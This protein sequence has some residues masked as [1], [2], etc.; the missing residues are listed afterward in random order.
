MDENYA[1]KD[2]VV[3]NQNGEAHRTI[4]PNS[5][6]DDHFFRFLE[7]VSASSRRSRTV[8]YALM[9]VMIATYGIH[10]SM[11]EP[12]WMQ[13][14]LLFLESAYYGLSHTSPPVK[15]KAIDYVNNELL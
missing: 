6:K 10:R 9:L 14:R 11:N 12:G 8:I 7:E 5:P 15:K 3:S 4:F 13:N 2:P 1:S